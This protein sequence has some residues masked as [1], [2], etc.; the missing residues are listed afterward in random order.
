M[1][2][3]F[4]TNV[5]PLR[6]A[7]L[8]RLL[9]EIRVTRPLLMEYNDLIILERN[10]NY[11]EQMV[12]GLFDNLGISCKGTRVQEAAQLPFQLLPLMQ[13]KIEYVIPRKYA[14]Q[15]VGITA[16]VKGTN[17]IAEKITRLQSNE[18]YEGIIHMTQKDQIAAADIYGLNVVTKTEKDCYE[19][20][21]KI[22]Q[23]DQFVLDE[24]DKDYIKA[25]KASGYRA[26]HQYLRWNIVESL[27]HNLCLEIHYETEE[28]N[29]KNTKSKGQ[30]YE[31]AHEQYTLM[32]LHKKHQMGKYKIIIV[33]HTGTSD[34]TQ[35]EWQTH[36][37]NLSA[38]MNGE[39][40]YY[41]I[42]G[43]ER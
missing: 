37:V 22:T 36:F 35:K 13:T 39:C 20:K 42:K 12:C 43:F 34:L 10:Q 32:K 28:D 30:Q 8:I 25:P 38:F 14:T 5:N 26:I 19:L 11:L 41:L 9:G 18:E 1:K 3:T 31:C 4:L 23:Q 17:S 40:K 33:D 7:E 2:T 21:E 29:I 15:I 24:P 16:R 27:L 6:T